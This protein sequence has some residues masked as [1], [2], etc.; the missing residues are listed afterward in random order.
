LR[1]KLV[2]L[3]ATLGGRDPMDLYTRPLRR[4]VAARW[5]NRA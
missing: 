2:E 5:L 4:S 3:V 1:E